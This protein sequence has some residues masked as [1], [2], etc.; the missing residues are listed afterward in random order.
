MPQI[1]AIS[2]VVI[3][4]TRNLSAAGAAPLSFMLVLTWA[5]TAWAQPA[6]PPR[7]DPRQTEKSIENLEAGQDRPKPAVRL[8]SRAKTGN[9]HQYQATVQ[10]QGCVD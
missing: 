7:Y 9:T 5:V 1:L 10:A 8:P 6:P 3:A 4:K 2:Q